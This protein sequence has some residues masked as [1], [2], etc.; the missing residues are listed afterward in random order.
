M[1]N[2][3]A[4]ESLPTPNKTIGRL[5]ILAA[6]LLWSTCGLFVKSGLFDDWGQA[7]GPLLAFWRAL[8]AALFLAPFARRPRFRLALVPMT[9]IFTVMSI[10]YLSAVA[11]TTAANAIWLQATAPWWVFLLSVGLLRRPIVRR[12]LTPLCFAALGVGTILLFEVHGQAVVGV[13]CGLIS[14]ATYGSVLLFLRHLRGENAVWLVVLNHSVVAL[15]ML[16]WVIW[17]GIWPSP[18]Q[19]LVLAAFGVFQMGVPYV[20]MARGLRTIGSHEAVVIALLEPVVNPLWVYLLGLETPSW[21]TVVGAGF[22]LA[23]LLLRYLLL[24]WLYPGPVEDVP[25]AA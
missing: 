25:D 16:P 20:C 21:W 17:L 12:D 7:E 9:A 22:I 8:F 15:V 5:W 3:N 24:P 10:T 23:G 19:L 4:P 14:G 18:G 6:A 2:S 13:A 11:L 1:P